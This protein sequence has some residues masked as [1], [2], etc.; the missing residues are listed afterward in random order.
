MKS[1][2]NRTTFV[3]E[4]TR[5]LPAGIIKTAKDPA[6]W[7]YLATALKEEGEA[8]G[9]NPSHDRHRDGWEM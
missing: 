5:F 7:D 8:F 3:N 1:E 2:E 6:F 4:L 9:R